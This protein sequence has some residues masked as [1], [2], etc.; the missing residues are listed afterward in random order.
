MDMTKRKGKAQRSASPF[1]V[2][3]GS[4]CSSRWNVSNSPFFLMITVQEFLSMINGKVSFDSFLH[5]QML[6]SYQKVYSSWPYLFLSRMQEEINACKSIDNA[7]PINRMKETTWLFKYMQVKP[8]TKS[9]FKHLDFRV[10]VVERLGMDRE[11]IK[12]YKLYTTSL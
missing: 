8:L 5:W 1:R 6:R 4:K 2:G 11:C 12:I 3:K 7:Y 9:K 10:R